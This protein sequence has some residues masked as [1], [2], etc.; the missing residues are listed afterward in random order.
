MKG[1]RT[2]ATFKSFSYHTCKCFNVQY[3]LFVCSDDDIANFVVLFSSPFIELFRK[4]I[5]L[6]L[7]NR[8]LA[9]VNID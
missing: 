5:H 6:N 1:A 4:M 7:N 2:I 3:A 8:A 9:A